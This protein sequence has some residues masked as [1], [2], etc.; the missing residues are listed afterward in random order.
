LLSIGLPCCYGTNWFEGKKRRELILKEK[1]IK[2]RKNPPG[3]LRNMVPPNTNLTNLMPL[4]L[5][6]PI[7]I[8]SS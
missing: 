1:E 8:L 6:T 4:P 7:Y 2:E 3:S 5:T